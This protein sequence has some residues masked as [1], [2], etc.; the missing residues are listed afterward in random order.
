MGHFDR[1]QL[2][3]RITYYLG[4][5]MLLCGGVVQ[6]NIG[7]TLFMAMSLTKR[8]LFEVSVML[9]IICMATQL[10]ALAL[11]GNQLSL[12]KREVAA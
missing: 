3:G 1:L 8:N 6:V 4:W 2:V 11:A 5:I 12:G 9:F 7:K 10:R